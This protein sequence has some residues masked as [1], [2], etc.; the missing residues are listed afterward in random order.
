MDYFLNKT[1]AL[2]ITFFPKK[3]FI[4]NIQCVLK[5]VNQVIIIDNTPNNDAYDLLNALSSVNNISIINNNINLGMAKALNQGIEW[6]IHKNLKWII[7]FD[8][9]TN[10]TKD[11]IED[12][13]KVYKNF[14]FP[15]KIAAIGA[16]Y[17]NYNNNQIAEKME[18]D[19]LYAI[20][21]DVITSGCLV[22]LDITAKIGGFDEKLFIDM[23]DTE[24]CLR[25][26]QNGYFILMTAKPLMIHSIGN[27]KKKRFLNFSFF[28]T[29]HAPFR[30]YYIF[31]NTIYL[32]KKYF[33]F[34]KSWS[35][36][37]ISNYL[38]KVF[39]KACFFEKSKVENFRFIFKGIIHGVLSRFEAN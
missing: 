34:D 6:A 4:N 30:R 9:D 35:F 20:V 3:E 16:N 39:I 15:E 13:Y 5:Q 37:M 29:N 10:I 26:R 11:F 24:Y 27:L 25:A 23:V 36:L 32:I 22:N 14:P 12:M 18:Q 31:R 19:K 33:L 8:Q 2:F 38:P 7:T 1:A 21:K 17:F 28:V